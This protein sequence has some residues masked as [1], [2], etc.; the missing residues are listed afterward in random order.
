MSDPG[1]KAEADLLIKSIG[2]AIARGCK[3]YD[4][5]GRHL[6]SIREVLEALNKDGSVEVE[7]PKPP[8]RR[9]RSRE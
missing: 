2:S 4:K 1:S 5:K 3:H 7:D 9:R 6:E 8:K